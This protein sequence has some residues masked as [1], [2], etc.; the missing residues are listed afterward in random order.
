MALQSVKSSIFN[1]T[2]NNLSNRFIDQ[3]DANI[4]DNVFEMKYL[5]FM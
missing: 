4:F 5:L 1:K 3:Y 2:F